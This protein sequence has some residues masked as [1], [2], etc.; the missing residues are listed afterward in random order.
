M[1]TV[2]ILLSDYECIKT[3]QF[4][5]DHITPTQISNELTNEQS[6]M[7]D[8][9]TQLKND[10]SEMKT[11]FQE[12][13]NHSKASTEQQQQM[14]QEQ[15]SPQQIQPQQQEIQQQQYQQLQLQIQQQQEQQHQQQLQ[16]QLQQE[17]QQQQYQQQLQLQIQQQQQLQHQQQQQFMTNSLNEIK[18]AMSQFNQL[19]TAKLNELEQRPRKESLIDHTMDDNEIVTIQQSSTTS[20]QENIPPPNIPPPHLDGRKRANSISTKPQRQPPRKDL[21]TM[22]ISKPKP[23]K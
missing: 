3:P 20:N 4:S 13:L 10:I 23:A 12:F 18:T 7:K 11:L 14:E 19:F 6:I 8:Q 5:P 1:P 9:I 16:F 22:A 21:A 2:I 17:Q 15:Q